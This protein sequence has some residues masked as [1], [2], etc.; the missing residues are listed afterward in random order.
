MYE[1]Q[2]QQRSFFYQ[3]KDDEKFQRRIDFI[4]KYVDKVILSLKLNKESYLIVPYMVTNKLFTSR[5][6]KIAFPIITYNELIKKLE[7]NFPDR[8]I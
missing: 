2:M 3:H 5:Y 4:N 7:T 1:D 6:K 8:H